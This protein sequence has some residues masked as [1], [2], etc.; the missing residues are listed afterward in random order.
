MLLWHLHFRGDMKKQLAFFFSWYVSS[1]RKNNRNFY[2]CKICL[3]VL[4][5]STRYLFYEPL[6]ILNLILSTV[7]FFQ[8]SPVAVHVTVSIFSSCEEVQLPLIQM[9]LQQWIHILVVLGDYSLS[10]NCNLFLLPHLCFKEHDG[11]LWSSGH[12]PAFHADQH[13]LG[14][15]RY[16]LE[17][18]KVFWAAGYAWV[19]LKYIWA[20]CILKYILKVE[21]SNFS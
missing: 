8:N 20:N 14:K 11:N 21:I 4:E 17:F 2:L 9:V 16:L 1:W 3:T 12:V 15:L 5:S 6:D 18:C 10:H 13:I 19:F 7:L